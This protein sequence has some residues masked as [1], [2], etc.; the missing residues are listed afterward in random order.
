MAENVPNQGNR[1]PD[2]VHPE[3][4]SKDESKDTHPQKTH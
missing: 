1:H 3:N 2:P 4:S